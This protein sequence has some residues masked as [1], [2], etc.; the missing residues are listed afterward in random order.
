MGSGQ[1]WLG[2]DYVRGR[3]CIRSRVLGLGCTSGSLGC[4]LVVLSTLISGSHLQMPM[5]LTWDVAWASG[6]V[7]APT[8]HLLA[9]DPTTPR[10]CV[11]HV[12]LEEA[13]AQRARGFPQTTVRESGTQAPWPV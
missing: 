7:P 8:P 12:A 5:Y 6:F 10:W 3:P 9:K 1:P 13:E 2:D 11:F 4:C